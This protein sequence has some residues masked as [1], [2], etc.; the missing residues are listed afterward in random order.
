[1]GIYRVDD[2]IIEFI[3]WYDSNSKNKNV[4]SLGVTPDKAFAVLQASF[5]GLEVVSIHDAIEA[6]F[7]HPYVV[8]LIEKLKIAVSPSPMII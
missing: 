3:S 7:N 1:M 8:G 4:S 5:A 6:G 2:E